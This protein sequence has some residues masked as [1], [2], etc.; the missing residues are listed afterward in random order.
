MAPQGLPR[1]FMAS[2]AAP[3]ASRFALVHPRHGS[4]DRVCARAGIRLWVPDTAAS[5]WL[6]WNQFL[7]FGGHRGLHLPRISPSS[8]A[9]KTPRDAQPALSGTLQPTSPFVPK[10]RGENRT[11]STSAAVGCTLETERG[12]RRCHPVATDSPSQQRAVVSRAEILPV[13]ILLCTAVQACALTWAVWAIRE[14]TAQMQ[15]TSYRAL[16][17]ILSCCGSGVVGWPAG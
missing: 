10:L 8:P 12:D 16:T 14:P 17:I 5:L 13:F 9:V 1:T 15:P 3:D 2:H 4:R 6:C 7:T 11:V